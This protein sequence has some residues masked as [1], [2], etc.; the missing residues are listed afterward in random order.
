MIRPRMALEHRLAEFKHADACITF[1]SGFTANLATVPA[2]T[3]EG[4]LI[5]SDELNHASIIDACRLSKARTIRY[6]H[7]DTTDPI[8]LRS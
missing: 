3:G 7:N 2:L 6:A 8:A 5:F 4:D 1:Q